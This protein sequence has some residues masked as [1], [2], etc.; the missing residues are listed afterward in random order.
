MKRAAGEDKVI[1]VGITFE[2][3]RALR[4]LAADRDISVTRLLKSLIHEFVATRY[5]SPQSVAD[6]VATELSNGEE[7]QDG[8]QSDG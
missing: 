5:W 1:Y 2:T 7:F 3:H 8:A 6:P 4:H